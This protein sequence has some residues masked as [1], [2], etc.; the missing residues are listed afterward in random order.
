MSIIQNKGA[1]KKIIFKCPKLHYTKKC[2]LGPIISE[3]RKQKRSCPLSFE[4]CQ[5]IK[6]TLHIFQKLKLKTIC[7]KILEDE[8]FSIL[9]K[10]KR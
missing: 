1:L 3:Q 5:R 8:I 2:A 7:A 4:C 9:I 10:R 6:A